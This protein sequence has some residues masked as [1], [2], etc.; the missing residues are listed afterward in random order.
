MKELKKWLKK[1][2]RSKVYLAY[3]MGYRSAS[4]ISNWI[5]RGSIP[6]QAHERLE[7]ALKK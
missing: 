3:L 7:K 2:K 4:T 5:T 1:P 6:E